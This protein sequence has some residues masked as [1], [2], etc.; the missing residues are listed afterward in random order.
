MVVGQG[1]HPLD[2]LPLDVKHTES[3]I[4]DCLKDGRALCIESGSNALTP[5]L[6]FVAVTGRLWLEVRLVPRRRVRPHGRLWCLLVL[7][8]IA[9]GGLGRRRPAV[10]PLPK[11]TATHGNAS[12]ARSGPCY[13]SL[14]EMSTGLRNPRRGRGVSPGGHQPPSAPRRRERRAAAAVALALA[15]ALPRST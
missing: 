5:L 6:Q 1:R 14:R 11:V 2:V 8:Q 13:R 12:A 4:K 7:A 3:G 9:E 10:V 15:F